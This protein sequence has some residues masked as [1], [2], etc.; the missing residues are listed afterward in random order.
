MYR[1]AL[2]TNVA[3]ERRGSG[4]A[5]ATDK[6]RVAADVLRAATM[7]R[8]PVVPWH[9]GSRISGTRSIIPHPAVRVAANAAGTEPRLDCPGV[10]K[11]NGYGKVNRL[12]T[13]FRLLSESL[14]SP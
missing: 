9:G 10:G 5:L 7:E 3:A 8:T 1:D 6:R 4:I 14:C 13:R 12:W 2:R 11:G